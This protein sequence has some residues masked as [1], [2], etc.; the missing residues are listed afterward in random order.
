MKKGDKK[1]QRTSSGH[2]K[3]GET[4]QKTGQIEAQGLSLPTTTTQEVCRSQ[5]VPVEKEDRITLLNTAMKHEKANITALH[6]TRTQQ[7]AE[8]LSRK[9]KYYQNYSQKS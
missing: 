4:K 7:T 8:V 3:A 6:Y 5:E 2:T 1:L 9:P